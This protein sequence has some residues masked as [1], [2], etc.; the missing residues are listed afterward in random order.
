M[1]RLEEDLMLWRYWQNA[2]DQCKGWGL[3]QELQRSPLPELIQFEPGHATDGSLAH[4]YE[5]LLPYLLQRHQQIHA[6]Q[7]G[8]M[9]P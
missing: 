8:S 6:H 2:R 3:M 1:K 9:S 5:R 4:A 7:P